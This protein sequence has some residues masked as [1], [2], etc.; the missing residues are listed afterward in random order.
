MYY[1]GKFADGG[2]G[3]EMAAKRQRI[4][5]PGSSFYGTSPGSSFMY[6]P[7]PY[8]YVNQ[9]PFPVV[10]LRGLPFDCTEADVA[11]FFHGLD[12]V[13]VLFVH[14]GG[15]FTGEGFC[16]LAYPFQV[17]FAL[18]RNRQ[19]MGR[20]YVE[21]FRSKRQEYYKAIANEV[22]DARGGIGGG[23]GSPRRSASRAKSYDEGKDSA[24]HTG[25]LR[26]RGLPFSATKDD[27]MEFFKDFVVSEDCIHIV[28]N[29]EGRPSGEAYVEF[30]SAEDSKAAM[31]KDRMTLGSRYIELFP[32]S[33]SEMDEAV[34]RGR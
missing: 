26:L 14:K 20:R 1:R 17:D 24:E 12:I 28:M 16:V 23:G 5:D 32:S 30:A 27:I 6:N 21:V 18:Q 10:R 7:P 4:V 3:R 31:A 33:Q 2:D 15:K 9:P 29:S 11:E 34:S 19:N 8:G 13:D 22:S 25:V